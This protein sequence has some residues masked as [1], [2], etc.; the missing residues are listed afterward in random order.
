M[1]NF[2]PPQ[3]ASALQLPSEGRHT[4]DQSADAAP[5][6]PGAGTADGQ[7]VLN[8]LVEAIREI[9]KELLMLLGQQQSP[10][11]NAPAQGPSA[12]SNPVSLKQ[13][14]PDSTPTSVH[15]PD[16]G[17]AAKHTNSPDKQATNQSRTAPEPSD[18]PVTYSTPPV[19]TAPVTPS[20]PVINETAKEKPVSY[21]DLPS[22]H[23]QRSKA[24]PV[25]QENVKPTALNT[26]ENQGADMSGMVG[27][28]KAANTTGGN[29]GEVV[30][31][32]T[33]D[34]LQKSMTGDKARTVRL[35]ADLSADSK[36]TISFGANK[37]LLGTGEGNKLHNIYLTSDKTASNDIFQ[38]LN[39]SH[40]SRYRENN[41][42]QMYI[43][44]GERYWI[45][46]D[47]FSGTKNE[48]PKGLDKLLYVGGKADNVSLTNSKFQNNEYG[49]ILGYPEDSAAAKA[50]YA[51]YPR[52]TIANNYFNDLDVRAPGLMRHGQ[53]DTF[54]NLIDKF[55][56]GFTVTGD[57]T[58]LSQAN[59]FEKGVDVNNKPSTGGVIDDYGDARF[60][61]IGSNVTFN[62]KSSTTNW[63]PTEY[64]RQVKTAEEA[65]VY[66]LANAGAK[67]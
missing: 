56:L 16:T 22:D 44:T 67:P 65:R 25:S 51:G 57:A 37:T 45:D 15:S 29:G 14:V 33:V 21:S 53:F 60:K 49:V 64:S 40:D 55:H 39:F 61:D 18:T 24:A 5:R 31:V 1:I 59:Y 27:F 30:T 13:S 54:N 12:G 66:D 23:S 20:V 43:N 36:V 35:G 62:Q 2:G 58:V 11:A 3:S 48:Q 4:R 32:H 46:H 26:P 42:M 28:A 17:S 6:S 8:K 52:M 10:S 34:E 7:P 19:K 63:T 9:L 38:N 50:T 41:D 47:T